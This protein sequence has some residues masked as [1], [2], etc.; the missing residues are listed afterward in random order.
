MV[1]TLCFHCQGPE[2]N[3]QSGNQDLT[4]SG[5]TKKES[6]QRLEPLERR[7]LGTLP[8]GYSVSLLQPST[9]FLAPDCL[10]LRSQ[11]TWFKADLSPTCA[12]PLTPRLAVASS[13]ER[14]PGMPEAGR[15]E[16]MAVGGGCVCVLVM[17]RRV[18]V[19]QK[20]KGNSW[21]GEEKAPLE[22]SE[23]PVGT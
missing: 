14:T 1:R 10:T 3:P 21:E 11:Q 23:W 19:H 12:M 2:F 7:A 18:K 5:Q 20:G 17:G 16:Q 9:S 8:L 22:K 15:W 6:L 4:S 13:T